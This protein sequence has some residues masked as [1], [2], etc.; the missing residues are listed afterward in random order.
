MSTKIE[1]LPLYGGS[2]NPNGHLPISIEGTTYKIAPELIGNGGGNI[3]EPLTDISFDI[4]DPYG[5]YFTDQST[6]L[7]CLTQFG[8][9]TPTLSYY[10]TNAKTFT[11]WYNSSNLED[12][13]VQLNS[14]TGLAFGDGVNV[15]IYDPNGFLYGFTGNCFNGTGKIEYSKPI[16]LKVFYS[17]D[18]NAFSLL[19]SDL[20]IEQCYSNGNGFA[21][22]SFGNIDIK[23]GSFN[24]NN[25][26][27]AVNPTNDNIVKIAHLDYVGGSN[28]F[29]SF[30]GKVIIESINNSLLLSCPSDMFNTESNAILH[31]PFYAKGTAFGNYAEANIKDSVPKNQVIYDGIAT[32]PQITDP[33]GT[34]ITVNYTDPANP[35]FNNITQL[36]ILG[37]DGYKNNITTQGLTN[38]QVAYLQNKT[39]LL[40]YM[41]DIP[42][43]SGLISDAPNDSNAYIR[44]GLTWVISYT[45]TAIDTL[46]NGKQNNLGYTAENTA[47]KGANNGYAGLDSSGKVPSSQLPSYVDDVLEYAN[48][49]SFPTTGESGKIYVALDTNLIYR[50]SGTTYINVAIGSVQSVNTKTGVVTLTQDDILDGTTYKQ[51]SVTEK[52]KLASITEIFTTA[53]KTAYDNAVSSLATLLATG[54]RLI[55]TSEITKLSNTSGTNTGDQNLSGLVPYTGATTDVDLGTKN[56]KVNNVF[57]GFTS[58]SAS[59]TLITLTATSKP[60]YLVTGSGGQTIKLPDATTLPNGA[61]FD[62]NN[63]QSSGAISVNNNSNTLVKSIPSGGYLVLTL[64]DNS[65]AAGSWDAHF[66]APSNASWSTNTLD[67]AGS[68]TSATWNGASIT[69]SKISSASNWNGKEDTA[70]KSTSTSD[71]ASTTK[72]PVWSA[73]LSYFDASRIRTIL[74][75]STLSGSN[76][77]DQDLSGLVPTT[78]T[79]NSKALSSN[80]TLNTDDIAESGTPTNKW[81]TNA[82]TIAST[83]TGFSSG[84][85]TVSSSD[86]ILTAIQ[87]IVGNIS[88]LVTGVSS[89]NSKTGAVSLTQDDILDGTTYK[90]YSATEKTKLG[91]ITGTNTGDETQSTILTKLGWYNYKNV[92]SSSAVTG[93]VSETQ[94]LQVSIPANTFS[95]NDILKIPLLDIIKTTTLAT[96]AINIKVSSSATMPTGTTGRIGFFTMTASNLN[97][98]INKIF[99]IK[100]GNLVGFANNVSVTSD[101]TTSNAIYSSL[102]FDVTVQNYLYI[103]ITLTNTGDSAY[104]N[105]FQLTNI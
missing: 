9:P 65:T 6:A 93:T 53:L 63:N 100:G 84:A 35:K 33:N 81:W 72:F 44:K 89:V 92:T 62:F 69:D 41:D 87:K 39:G 48:L 88:A 71:S 74:G 30:G 51:Y 76:T 102:A 78:R 95:A 49:A 67:Y 36:N 13:Y 38:N 8:L 83:L 21:N 27:Q 23:F 32:N 105:G 58:I 5:A 61:I 54:S 24:G 91:A 56:L 40:A 26:F 46:L 1:Q 42:N 101:Y 15:Y 64:I 31:L 43:V 18:D 22:S 98:K 90:Q 97:V 50:W 75:I 17:P 4:Y 28:F 66:Q 47:N 45:K 25:A 14:N 55:T 3:L 79:V 59:G 34:G 96:V 10:N 29:N 103:S 86:S 77:G 37:N 12:L 11:V 19:S 16:T 70:N 57:E 68:I 73:I 7:T 99:E 85:G 20:I 104:L 94:V 82:R 60:S 2:P 52:N 80:I